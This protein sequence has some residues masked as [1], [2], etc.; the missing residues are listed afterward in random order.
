MEVNGSDASE[1]EMAAPT[2]TKFSGAFARTDTYIYEG[3]KITIS[4]NSAVHIF[5]NVV[6]AVTFQNYESFLARKDINNAMS[7]HM[8]YDLMDKCFQTKPSH[9]VTFEVKPGK[10]AIVFKV[11]FEG[12]FKMSYPVAVQEKILSGDKMLTLRLTEMES[13]HQEEVARLQERIKYLEM[14]EVI[15]GYHDKRYGDLMQFKRSDTNLD[16]TP[17]FEHKRQL[18]SINK[19]QNANT[20]RI[21]DEQMFIYSGVVNQ[22]CKCGR[23]KIKD[24]LPRCQQSLEYEIFIFSSPRYF[25]PSIT[26]LQLLYKAGDSSVFWTSF[27][28]LPNLQTLRFENFRKDDSL[29]VLSLVQT[30][31]H[32]KR[33]VLV[34]CSFSPICDLA[35][36]NL[37]CAA[38]GIV[39]DRLD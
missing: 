25:L 15:L 7:L 28:S 11:N 5:I 31:Q 19:L 27:Q 13:R 10:L 33:I 2:I 21:F 35:K 39:I 14:E 22:V 23:N 24:C 20:I 17:F 16:F 36:V 30:S 12:Y 9:Q 1:D 32:L 29:H 26:E 6:N 8:F 3:Y 18:E 34:N 38:R 37:E 4:F